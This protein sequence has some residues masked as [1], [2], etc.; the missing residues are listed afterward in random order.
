MIRELSKNS[1]GNIYVACGKDINALK[2]FE[3]LGLKNVYPFGWVEHDTVPT[4]FAGMNAIV[5]GS[6]ATASV[7]EI[8]TARTKRNSINGSPVFPGVIMANS[9]GGPEINNIKWAEHH[10]LGVYIPTAAEIG[11]ILISF[12]DAGLNDDLRKRF[13]DIELYSIEEWGRAR[14]NPEMFMK[15]YNQVMLYL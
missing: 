13:K 4:L 2:H 1:V 9:L 11:K 14:E 5:L 7:S 15:A 10:N 6:V 8:S 12:R 3:A